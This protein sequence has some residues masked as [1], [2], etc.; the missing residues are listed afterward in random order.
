MADERV[1][2]G[3]TDK[4]NFVIVGLVDLRVP[5][6]LLNRLEHAAEQVLAQL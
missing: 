1:R 3:T 4:D 5:E 2:M 6:D